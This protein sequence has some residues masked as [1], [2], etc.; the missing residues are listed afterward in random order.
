M[1]D[2]EGF[3]S[4]SNVKVGERGNDLDDGGRIRVL[5]RSVDLWMRKCLKYCAFLLRHHARFP[6]LSGAASRTFLSTNTSLNLS[7]EWMECMSQRKQKETTQQPDTA[8]P[9]NILGCCLVSL[10]FPCDIHPVHPVQ[11]ADIGWHSGNGKKLSNS[12]A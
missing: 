9:G 6:S 1:G 10:C 2:L 12:Q 7:T 8:G 5:L 3:S 4:A 11:P